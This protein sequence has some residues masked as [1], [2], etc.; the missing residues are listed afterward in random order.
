MKKV[1]V[2]LV[3]VLSFMTVGCGGKESAEPPVTHT[4]VVCGSRSNSCFTS[5]LNTEPA[6]EAIL[7]STRSCGSVTLIVADGKPYVA[8]QFI[9][10]ASEKKLSEKKKNQIANKQAEQIL[11]TAKEVK[12]ATEEVD[13]LSAL[14]L[15]GRSLSEVEGQK[16]ILVIDSGLS[17]A[18]KINCLNTE[19][20][21][22]G[23][24][25]NH[26]KFLRDEKELP[27]LE[28]V[29]VLWMG[30]ADTTGQQMPCP[31]IVRDKL[32]QVWEKVLSGAESVIF[33]NTLPGN[34]VQKDLPF[35]SVVDY[36]EEK[37][38]TPVIFDNEKLM[39]QPDSVELMDRTAAEKVLLPMVN[40][41]KSTGI[42]IAIFGTT[43]SVGDNSDCVVFSEARA[44]TVKD[45]MVDDMGL[46]EEQIV[47]VK[48]LGY[49]NIFHINDRL[50][51][52]T[53]DPVSAQKNRSVIVMS[54]DDASK[55]GL[56]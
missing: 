47:L 53:L 30:L 32:M 33:S 34:E 36:P 37:V 48:G 23:V 27:A 46:P 2:C 9:V 7:E 38:F 24:T 40:E 55:D 26:F 12:A 6:K 19:L 29:T 31:A 18:G 21:E 56:V 17:T 22:H 52:G 1:L 10:E 8:E 54:F 35:V 11:E 5:F 25:E 13:L 3:L 45:L 51:N 16:Q 43:A 4:A 42:Q 44:K 20:L 41:L 14:Q 28:G 39:F 15:A 49:E 50:Q